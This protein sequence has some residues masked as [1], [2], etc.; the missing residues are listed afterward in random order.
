VRSTN[1]RAQLSVFQNTVHD[2]IAKVDVDTALAWLNVADVRLHGVETAF[3]VWPTDDWTLFASLAWVRGE[4]VDADDDLPSIP[5]LR[6]RG[7]VRWRRELGLERSLWSE[8]VLLWTDGQTAPGP[9]ERATAS[10]RRLDLRG[11]WT[12]D[13]RWSLTVAV[14]NLTDSA[15]SDH[16]SRV[17]QDLGRT[18]QAGLNVRIGARLGF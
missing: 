13:A 15:Y 5:P 8:L 17:W 9:G 14:E 4:V 2:Y 7:G 1:W 6:A 12:L 11:G 16:L 3:E 18:S 10:W